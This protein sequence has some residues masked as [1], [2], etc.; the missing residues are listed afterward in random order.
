[1]HMLANNYIMP[2]TQS[3]IKVSSICNYNPFHGKCQRPISTDSF[4]SGLQ[5]H[6]KDFAQISGEMMQIVLEIHGTWSLI[7]DNMNEAS[8][9]IYYTYSSNNSSIKKH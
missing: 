2:P 7:H 4:Y 8:R 9:N 1:M 5:G 3:P 6:Q